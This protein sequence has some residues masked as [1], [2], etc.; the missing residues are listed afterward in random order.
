MGTVISQGVQMVVL[1]RDKLASCRVTESRRL[2]RFK[3][4]T[5]W[6]LSESCG[7]HIKQYLGGKGWQKPTAPW[8]THTLWVLSSHDALSYPSDQDHKPLRVF[9][10]PFGERRRSS[11]RISWLHMHSKPRL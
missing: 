7:G 9:P 1:A 2:E 6:L 11:V 5:K 8:K 4:I 3:L 10:T